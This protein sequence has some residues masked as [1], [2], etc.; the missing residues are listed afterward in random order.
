MIQL[1][2]VS[3]SF[4]GL[5]VIS[6]LSLT[7][8]KGEVIGLVGPSG[9]GKTTLLRLIA[10]LTA[11]D[12]GQVTTTSS[13]LSYV[14]QEP[15]LLPWRTAAGNVAVALR[16]AGM[17]RLNARLLAHDW[18][19]RVGLGRFAG[20]YPAQLSGGMQQRVA[21]ARAFAVQPDV[22]LLDEPFSHLDDGHKQELL[23]SL[24][25]LVQQTGV[26]VVYVTHTLSELNG[27][28]SRVLRLNA[29]A[30]GHI[31]GLT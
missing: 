28:A 6:S 13:R 22:L 2:R 15:R 8:V 20:Y 5:P 21:L 23:D 19:E 4:N 17:D 16:A 30:C 24:R 11:P 1:D 29:Q 7:V 10:G 3:K 9:A 31:E 25:R 26:T 14:F 27:L 12:A 18:L